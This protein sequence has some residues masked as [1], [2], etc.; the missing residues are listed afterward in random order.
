VEWRRLLNIIDIYERG[1]GQKINLNKT[2]FFFSHN[3]SLSRRKEI[4]D[5]SGLSESNR[6]DSY[7]GLPT[8]VGKNRN[9][10]FKEI[11]ERVIRKLNNWKT[12]LLTLVGKE[13]LLKGCCAGHSY[14]F[15]ECFLSSCQPL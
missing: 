7:L 10:A 2:A 15:Y 12:K 5:L 14:L 4:L 13:V 1:S 3:T 8:L 9:H 6:Y 11:K